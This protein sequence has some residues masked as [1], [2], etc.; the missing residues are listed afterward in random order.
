MEDAE[1]TSD[2]FVR[3]HVGRGDPHETDTHWRCS[4][5]VASFNHRM[6]FGFDAPNRHLPEQVA[7]KLKMQVYDR[8][9]F[10]S[11]DFICEFELDLSL[12]VRDVRLTQ[13]RTHLS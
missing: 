6:I 5:G 8:D 2:V 12:L 1:G 3:A 4:T 7:Y 9:L 10:K 13:K 11:N